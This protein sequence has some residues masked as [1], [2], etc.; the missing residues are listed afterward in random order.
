MPGA[1]PAQS[2]ARVGRLGA[3]RTLLGGIRQARAGRQQL[4]Q[5]GQRECCG[6]AAPG[7]SGAAGRGVLSNAAAGVSGACS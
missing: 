4:L 6:R 1:G 2:C 3:R 7:V 5:R